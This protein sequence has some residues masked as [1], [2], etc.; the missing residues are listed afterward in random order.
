MT[1]ISLHA[2]PDPDPRSLEHVHVLR[3][4]VAELDFSGIIYILYD[5]G[6]LL[7]N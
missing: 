4:F 6:H 7:T 3:F 2:E 1:Y 5:Q